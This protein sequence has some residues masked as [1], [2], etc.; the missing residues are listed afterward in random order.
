MNNQNESNNSKLSS[1]N[2]IT[3]DETGRALIDDISLT[4]MSII[5]TQEL[6]LRYFNLYIFPTEKCN[7]RC[8]YCY[9]DFSVG[10]MKPEMILAVKAFLDRRCA[11]LDYLK[12]SWFGGEPLIAKDI[13]LD[14]SEYAT[15]LVNKYPKLRYEGDMTTN[16]Y[17]L[18]Y[19]TITA[20]VDV[21]VRDFQISLDGPAEVHDCSRISVNGSGTYER[22]WH[23]LL[24]IHNSCLPVS[25]LLRIHFS[26]DTLQLLDPLIENIKNEFIQDTRFSVFFKAIER[27]GSRNDALMNTFSDAEKE[28][29]VKFLQTK[30]FGENIASSQN[31]S[32]QENPICYAS[33]PN[34]LVIR[35]NGNIG[36]CTVALYDERNHVASLQPDGT[37]KVIPGRLTPW[38]RGIK[39]LDP[40]ALA[41]P[42]VYLPSTLDTI[43]T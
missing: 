27:L 1:N 16:G 4:K 25:I 32:L 30:L 12:I 2:N 3:L 39:D 7:F 31:Y 13:V 10:R 24:A 29:A 21:G 15:K 35:A 38:L 28:Q 5:S 6:S 42:L 17:L 36:K 34:S 43:S 14:I 33:R 41:C 11:D 40:S 20:L 26:P 22:I 8:T 18:D 9:E 37:L 19:K 23:N